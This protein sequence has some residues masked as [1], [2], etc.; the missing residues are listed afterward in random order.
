MCKDQE[1]EV[2]DSTRWRHSKITKSRRWDHRQWASRMWSIVWNKDCIHWRQP[3]ERPI[4]TTTRKRHNLP[5][6]SSNS[7][8]SSDKTERCFRWWRERLIIELLEIHR[9]LEEDW[10]QQL[11]RE[12]AHVKEAEVIAGQ[13]WR[14]P[15][16]SWVLPSEQRKGHVIWCQW[17]WRILWQI[18]GRRTKA[19]I[20]GRAMLSTIDQINANQTPE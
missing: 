8:K 15:N 10:G 4:S 5:K 17:N 13:A 3:M 19:W 2:T 20:A 18:M 7:W 14:R 12:V 11:V 6:V 16:Q 9:T 1:W